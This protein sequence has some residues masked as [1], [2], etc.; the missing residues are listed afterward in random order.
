[1]NSE[2]ADEAVELEKDK[3]TTPYSYTP[4]QLQQLLVEIGVA[5]FSSRISAGLIDEIDGYQ[6]I[7][8]FVRSD[9]KRPLISK[10]GQALLHRPNSYEEN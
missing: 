9:T 10:L 6:A 8:Q 7:E 2:D 1:M 4:E 5:R 3:E